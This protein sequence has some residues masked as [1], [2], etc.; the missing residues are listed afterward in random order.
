MEHFSEFNLTPE[1]YRA[2]ERLGYSKPTPIQQ[3]AFSKI[4]SGRD[5]EGIAQ[6]GTGKT[7]AYT[8]PLLRNLRKPT[9]NSPRILILVPT[10][11]L[12]L[13]VVES[14]NNLCTELSF[15]TIGV[16]GG[17]NINSQK[18]E[19]EEGADI[20]VA[21]P[22]RLYDL[23][24]SRALRLKGIQKLVIDEVD[25]M[26]D[27]GFRHQ[28]I[29]IFDVL[30]EQR[31]NI[32]FSATMTTDVDE[33]ITSFFKAPNK[34]STAIS[35]TP[36]KNIKQYR[37]D[38]A[39]YNTKVNLLNFLLREK[40]H[41]NKVL[42]FVDQKRIAD[43]LFNQIALN[44][45]NECAVLHSNK[46]QNYRTNA[47]EEFKTGSS[48]ILITTDIMAR[49]IDINDISHVISFNT[50]AFPENYMHRIG[51][52]GRAEKKGESI[53]FS[54]KTEQDQRMGI[55]TYMDFKIECLVWPDDV[56]VSNELM[57]EEKNSKEHYNPHKKKQKHET[58]F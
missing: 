48:R 2:I 30:P 12:V 44:F 7:M 47:I 26:L 4:C 37:F 18:R 49:G 11:E 9:Q 28:L 34:V 50:P 19:V 43:R 33:L 27:L 3:S 36:L 21:T 20:I 41:Y 39:N 53:L 31:Q 56:D 1:L 51:R 14:V 24:L 8:L 17:T 35:G 42:V 46:S 57:P 55:E 45:A 6:T 22:G 32:M 52:T 29:N 54:T 10:R 16:F 40:E 25:V 58:T 5:L 15:K 38:A 23:A 13:Q